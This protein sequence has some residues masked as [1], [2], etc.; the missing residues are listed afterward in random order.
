MKTQRERSCGRILLGDNTGGKAVMLRPLSFRY[1][2]ILISV[3][4]PC[5][6]MIRSDLAQNSTSARPSS[7][8]LL[9]KPRCVLNALIAYI[10]AYWSVV[11]NFSVYVNDFTV[12][13]LYYS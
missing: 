6:F 3:G 4:C 10:M 9:C 11:W 7:T 13:I 5:V 1:A 12:L 8:W 2:G